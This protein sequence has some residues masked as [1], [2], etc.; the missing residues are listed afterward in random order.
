MKHILKST[1]AILLCAVIAVTTI[2][3]DTACGGGNLR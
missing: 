1:I 2:G 3:L